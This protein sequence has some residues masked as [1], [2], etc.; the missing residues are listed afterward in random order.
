MKKGT[1]IPLILVLFFSQIGLPLMALAAEFNPNYLIS[2]DELQDASSMTRADIDL[3][4]DQKGSY[5]RNYKAEDKDGKKRTASDIIYRTSQ[6]YQINP[7]YLL[8]KLQKEQSLITDTDP[9]NKQLDW[10]T[11]YGVCDSCSMDDPRIQKYKGFGNQVDHAAGIMRWYYDNVGDESWIK[12]ANKTYTIDSKAVTPAN[13]AT[14]F[15]YTYTPHIQGNENFWKLWQKW[16]EGSYPNGTL[17]KSAEDST[18]YL[19]QDGKKRPFKSMSALITRYDAKRII[20][21]PE[22]EINR[23]PLGTPISFPNYSILKSDSTYYLLDDDTLRPIDSEATFK[24]IGYHPDEVIDVEKDE[25]DGIP[26]GEMITAKNATNPFGEIVYIKETGSWYFIKDDISHAIVDPQLSKIA[27]PTLKGR[28][29]TIAELQDATAGD[30]IKFPDGT[31]LKTPTSPKIYVVENG[32]KRHISNEK[33]FLALGYQWSNVVTTNEIMSSFYINGP[34]LSLPDSLVNELDGEV[35]PTPPDTSTPAK[36]SDV[37][38][39]GPDEL[40]QFVDTGK[41]YAISVSDTTFVGPKFET[42]VNTYLVAEAATGKILAGKNIDVVRPLAS[43]AKVMTAN[44]LMKKN[45]SLNKSV[46]FNLKEHKGMYG[47]FRL[48]DGEKVKNSDLLSTMLVSSNNTASRMIV[49]G[50]EKNESTF[51]KDMNAQAKSWGLSKT[52]FTE[53]SGADLGNI[54]TAREYLKVFTEATK[55]KTLLDTLGKKSYTYEETLDLDENPTHFDSHSNLLIKQSGLPF[56]ILASKTG[57]LIE[58]GSG[59][60]MLVERKTDKKRF[61]I[62][63]MGNPNYDK[64][65][66]TPEN[67]TRWALKEF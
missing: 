56:T 31:L 19:L 5:L 61:V 14:A 28:N 23:Y 25:I 62:I 43:F 41:M 45:L 20:I 60:V 10:A 44:T 15:L 3:F 27:F 30:P 53:P 67:L 57:Y 34:A 58:S 8:V 47:S 63:T 13:N 64:R 17:F 54:S 33:M 2:D 39:I 40:P 48:V 16:F 1:K 37:V 29:G 52:R 11:G 36:T 6:E 59:L 38:K 24:K 32:K 46:T 22:G 9:S 51:V 65:F 21:V 26:R 55:N 66:D 50:I 4:L 42:D 49:D 35:T 12:Q 7:K 18:I